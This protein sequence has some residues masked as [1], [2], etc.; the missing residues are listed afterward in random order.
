MYDTHNEVVEHV[1]KW[2]NEAEFSRHLLKVKVHLF[3]SNLFV[4][5][6]N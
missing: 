4:N 1:R 6:F 3:T 5:E 2:F